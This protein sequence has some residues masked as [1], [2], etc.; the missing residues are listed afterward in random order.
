MRNIA[1]GKPDRTEISGDG[2]DQLRS[3]KW[4]IDEDFVCHVEYT[5]NSGRNTKGT[6]GSVGGAFVSPS[7]YLTLVIPDQSYDTGKK[8]FCF[9]AENWHPYKKITQKQLYN[10][11]NTTLQLKDFC[12]K[13]GR[14]GWWASVLCLHSGMNF[15]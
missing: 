8:Y 4:H 9:G 2:R 12:G 5:T 6:V 14:T 7:G 11:L 13:F 10:K 3:E 15:C 1:H